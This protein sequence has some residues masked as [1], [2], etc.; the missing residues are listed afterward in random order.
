MT[1]D[2]NDASKFNYHAYFN[3]LNDWTLQANSATLYIYIVYIIPIHVI[4]IQYNFFTKIIIVSYSYNIFV[5]N[6]IDCSR[7]QVNIS[8]I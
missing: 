5:I 6:F 3:D 1:K 2:L 8:S 7:S 4:M